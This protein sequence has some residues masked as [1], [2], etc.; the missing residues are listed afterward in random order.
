ML[1]RSGVSVPQLSAFDDFMSGLLE[2]W[3]IPGAALGISRHG[4]LM[5]ARGY[6]L[7]ESPSRSS[8]WRSASR[9]AE[10]SV[11]PDSLFRIAGISKTLTASAILRLV[12]DGRLSLDAKAFSVLT[13]SACQRICALTTLPF[14]IC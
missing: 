12:E 3:H 1:F 10:E 6:G 4:R 11:Q 2:K 7:A 13:G 5:L 8:R 9:E 14:A